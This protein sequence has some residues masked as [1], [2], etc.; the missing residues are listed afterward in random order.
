MGSKKISIKF[1]V[2]LIALAFITI[3]IT[4][5]GQTMNQQSVI[6]VKTPYASVH[7]TGNLTRDFNNSVIYV[8]HN[9]T[10]WGPGN[11]IWKF[12]AA[13]NSTYLFLG[14]NEIASNNGILVAISNNTGSLYGTYNFSTMNSWQRNIVFDK[15]VNVFSAIYFGGNDN[16]NP[17]GN[18]TYIINSQLSSS[19][20]SSSGVPVH[21]IW[22]LSPGNNTTEIGIPLKYIFENYSGINSINVAILLI[23][24]SSSWVGDAI[25]YNQQGPYSTGNTYFVVNSTIMLTG[26]RY[27]SSYHYESIKFTGNVEKDFAGELLYYNYNSTY[28]GSGNN[29]TAM[30]FAYN[31]SY[32]FIGISEVISGNGLLI[33]IS[34]NTGSGYGTYNLSTLRTQPAS[35]WQRNIT[36]T[37]PVNV[38]SFVQFSG[39]D[40]QGVT[41]NYT[42]IINSSAEL[43]NSSSTGYEISSTWMFN[44]T[45]NSTELAI[46]IRDIFGSYVGNLNLSI[47]AL[48]IGGSS[49]WVGTGIPY[50]QQGP[51]S[52]GN[53]YFVMN[54]MITV[55]VYVQF[56]N[57]YYGNIVF[58][59]NVSKDFASHLVYYN[60]NSTYWGSGNNL[61]AMYLAYN[62]SYLFL[63][64]K[65]IISGNWLMIA[66]SNNSGSQYGTYNLSMLSQFSRSIV[67]TKPVNYISVVDFSGNK[68][69]GISSNMTFEITSKL[70]DSNTSVSAIQ[71]K[72]IWMFSSANNSTELAIPMSELDPSGSLNV[73]LSISAL[74]VGGSSSW[75]GDGIPFDQSGPYSTGNTYFKVNS[76][77]SFALQL[78]KSPVVKAVKTI[79]I[80]LAIIFNDHQPLYALFNTSDYLLPWTEAHATA[81]YIE[82]ALIAHMYDVNVTYELSG[83]LIYQLL[84]IYSSPTYNNTFIEDAYIPYS[85]VANNSTLYDQVTLDYFSIPSYVFEL[86]EPASR[87]YNTIHELWLSGAKLNY[88]YYEDA[89]VL[90]F[91]YDVSTPLVEGQLGSQWKNSTIWNLHNQTSFNQSDLRV[92]LNYSKW[93]TGQVLPAFAND[94]LLSNQGSHNVEL[95][96]S[97]MFHPIVPL[98]LTNNI[99]GPDGTIYKSVYSTDLI[100]QINYSLGQFHSVFGFWPTG[101]YSPE[102]AVTYSMIPYY[103]MAGAQW[104]ATAEYTLQQSGINAL[105]YGNSGSN[106]TTMENLYTPYIVMGAN[107]SSIY[108]FFRD[109]YLSNAWGFNYGSLP[110]WTAV[111]DFINYLKGIYYEIPLN[112]HNQ[113]LVTVVLDGENWMFMSPFAEDGVPFLEDLYAAL[114]QNSSYIHTV[115]PTQYIQ[116]VKQNNIQLPTL[117]YLATGSWNRGSGS[118]APYQS[119]TALEQ[120]S[121]Y[122]VQDFYWEALNYVRNEILNY[123]VKNGLYQ[124][125]NYSSYKQL[126]ASNTLEGRLSRAWMAIYDAEGSDWYFTMAPWDI[127]GS[128]TAPFDHL[129]KY[130]LIYALEQLNLPVPQFL[131][132]NSYVP[133][134]PSYPGISNISITPELNGIYGASESVNGGNAYSITVT[135]TWAGS[136]IYNA[137]GLIS[138]VYIAYD[139]SNLYLM[140]LPSFNPAQL[141]SNKNLQLAVYIS[142]AYQG[143]PP[144][145][146]NDNPFATYVTTI[147]NIPL[148]FPATYAAVFNPYTFTYG[149]NVGSYSFY[150]AVGLQQM[151]YVSSAV[152]TPEVVGNSVQMAIPLNYMNLYPGQSFEMG[153]IIWN[154]SSGQYSMI[155]PMKILLPSSLAKFYPVS[156]I[157]NTVPANGPG[158]YTYPDQPTQIP[159]GSLDMQWV[160]VSMN[161][162]F[163]KWNFTFG[164]LW[165][166]WGAPYGFSNQIINVYVVNPSSSSGSTYLGPGPNANSS[167]PWQSMIYV[168]GWAIYVQTANGQQYTNGITSSVN[169]TSRTISVTVPLQYIG[170]NIES[171]KYIIISG[172]YDGYGVDG[173]RIVEKN[174]TTNSG[175]QG[176]GGDPPWSS[177]IYS[178]IAPATVGEGNLTQQEAL[179]YAPHKIPTLVPISLPLISNSTTSKVQFNPTYYS[180]E[181]FIWT[182]G[183]SLELLISNMSGTNYIYY[184]TSSDGKQWSSL[185][186]IPNTSG[187]TSISL[188]G[189]QTS[190]VLA[191][192][193]SGKVVLY[194]VT[195]NGPTITLNAIKSLSSNASFISIAGT[196]YYDMMLLSS[197]Y[198]GSSY[199]YYLINPMD[200]NGRYIAHGTYPGYLVYFNSYYVVTISSGKYANI[201]TISTSSAS[202][203]E[204]FSIGNISGFTG[205][206][207]VTTNNLGNVWVS[208]VTE[209]NCTFTLMIA[210]FTIGSSVLNS[211]KII[212]TPSPITSNEVSLIKLGPLNYEVAVT[213]TQRGSLA[214][215]VWTYFPGISFVQYKITTTPIKTTPINYEVIAAAL[216]IIIVVVAIAVLALNTARKKKAKVE[217]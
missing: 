34:N 174:N 38:L 72:S 139:P 18:A 59:G 32:I 115:T 106:V 141:I 183:E 207:S 198:N 204:S 197:V 186:Q 70:S 154:S 1:L 63:G 29:L 163:V 23:G 79:P 61:S 52:K 184:S 43:S 45:L 81:E 140:I 107:N 97:P 203:S 26:I 130:A 10:K 158:N 132:N 126:M 54:Q 192:L 110:T 161:S 105:A 99:S 89:K 5:S 175:W 178:Y 180:G 71:I 136:I 152:N 167:Q 82:Q 191:A 58:T 41:G 172:S 85:V 166:I 90:W 36:F 100:A 157:H 24:G 44:S 37:R 118:A 39:N 123:Q 47:G 3:P 94:S 212:S 145:V 129:F 112:H 187:V 131:L 16:S 159:W 155:S 188:L 60:K 127:G 165:N 151:Q 209:V 210:N 25:P 121:G 201:M 80:N 156:S 102:L 160:N 124:P 170:Y 181:Q 116:Y 95:F 27:V 69:T 46:P 78:T 93:L 185:K 20:F 22:Y 117:H 67:F 205:Y 92:I 109:G 88:T 150:E 6:M 11:S 153:I 164:Q 91:L 57:Q 179:Q 202:N 162:N 195:L 31:S 64:F 50:N 12:Y 199:S 177:N 190:P 147:G 42:F 73:N 55:P 146:E 208:Y 104:T 17:S 196:G 4:S 30:Y 40:N 77:L 108:M 216:I 128:N 13:Y 119:N 68:N 21:S 75:V 113:T 66:I 173:W 49:S 33:A 171:Y 53:T 98:L 2:V 65:E 14:I 169:Y 15:P 76:T 133:V 194:N 28:W 206:F 189:N 200:G 213:W 96:T 214:Y 143:L 120:W 114:E 56:R 134:S 9:A 62:N 86:N 84:Y 211:Y 125:L 149:S 193:Y 101:L 48:I 182:S 217:K 176:G 168:S 148:G 142:G 138:S 35:S 215:G 51:Y 83:S 137:T 8:N 144:A 74:I 87:L 7:F 19:N 103:Y 135:N 122:T 111:N